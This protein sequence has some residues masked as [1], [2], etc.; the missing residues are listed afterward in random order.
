M[1]SK[2]SALDLKVMLNWQKDWHDGMVG[3]I[4]GSKANMK[5]ERRHRRVVYNRCA[6]FMKIRGLSREN[7]C[8]E[9][10]ELT[11]DQKTE[12]D[13]LAKELNEHVNQMKVSIKDKM[14][15]YTSKCSIGPRN[16]SGVGFL[17]IVPKV[18]MFVVF[19]FPSVRLNIERF[20]MWLRSTC[21][22]D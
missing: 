7:A 3:R 22:F 13:Q 15:Q 16:Y 12:Y 4:F 20:L 1:R 5:Y 6:A 8:V 10:A 17:P 2:G 19:A 18:R 14:S 11:E 9:W 21:P